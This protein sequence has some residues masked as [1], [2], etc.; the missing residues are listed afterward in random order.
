EVTGNCG[1]SVF[2]ADGP[3]ADQVTSLIGTLLGSGVQAWPDLASYRTAAAGM[4]LNVAPLVGH[5]SIRAAVLGF[6]DRAPDAAELRAMTA[7]L[8]DRGG[9]GRMKR[10]FRDGLPGWQN[11]QR[12]AGWD[13]IVIASC[14][15]QPELEGRRAD[16]LGGDPAEAVFDLIAQRR[17]Q[18]TMIAHTM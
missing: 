7:R 5:G 4:Y 1:F 13:G 12:A 16:E 11:Q 6:A 15:G 2:P 14:A 8:G 9:R 10:D 17:G 18:V 3:H